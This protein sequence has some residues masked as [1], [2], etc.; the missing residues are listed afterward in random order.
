[1]FY[2]LFIFCSLVFLQYVLAQSTCFPQGSIS[3]RRDTY[4]EL[5]LFLT[6]DI[7]NNVDLA[8]PYKMGLAIHFV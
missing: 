1:M 5:G 7:L 2:R 6:A 3:E 8:T 4:N